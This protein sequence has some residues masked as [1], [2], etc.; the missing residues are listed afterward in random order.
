MG[1]KPEFEQ[2]V[3]QEKL[4]QSLN[5]RHREGASETVWST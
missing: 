5:K 1:L 4:S 2:E 3:K